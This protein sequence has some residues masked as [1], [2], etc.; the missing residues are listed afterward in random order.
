M[1]VLK[2][3]WTQNHEQNQVLEFEVVFQLGDSM[4]YL[5]SLLH[6][7]TSHS[8]GMF[9]LSAESVQA[10]LVKFFLWGMPSTR[11]D[12]GWT[13]QN[14]TR[15]GFF[16]LLWGAITHEKDGKRS[17]RIFNLYGEKAKHN[18]TVV[19]KLLA[20]GIIS[21]STKRICTKC[22]ESIK[23]N[24]TGESFKDE[25]S[26]DDSLKSSDDDSPDSIQSQDMLSDSE[27]S[28]NENDTTFELVISYY[29]KGMASLVSKDISLL[30][31]DKTTF[32]IA[33]S[34]DYNSA[35]WLQDR[36]VPS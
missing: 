29:L 17:S 31:N 19:N 16:K 5:A 33:S 20:R 13:R 32:S 10:I 12:K 23:S 28:N 27:V 35:E 25:S 34:L 11:R 30:Y 18:R 14:R 36:P 15:P 7:H 8:A 3:S 26:D 22:L 24:I 4:A 1:L 21:G 6:L 2:L 9:K